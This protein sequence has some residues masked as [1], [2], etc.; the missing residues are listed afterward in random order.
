VPLPVIRACDG[1]CGAW[2]SADTDPAA[3]VLGHLD[4]THPIYLCPS[5]LGKL[6][7]AVTPR[8]VE[9]KAPVHK[10]RTH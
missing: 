5:C 4:Y 3:Q 10:R 9:T 1:G 2:L 6:P 7:K 8:V